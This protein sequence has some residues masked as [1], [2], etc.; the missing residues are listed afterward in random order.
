MER[1]PRLWEAKF[2]H[3]TTGRSGSTFI[4]QILKDVLG[5]ENVWAGHD[6]VAF[7]FHKGEKLVI[8]YRD[9]RD[10]AAS[11]WRINNDIQD[12]VLNSGA[13]KM[14]PKDVNHYS[15]MI[16]G[17][18]RGHMNP[19]YKAHPGALLMKYEDFFPDNYGYIFERIEKHFDIKLSSG[20]RVEIKKKYSLER[21][22]QRAAKFSSFKQVDREYVHGLHIYKGDIGTW[23][24]LVPANQHA[25]M[26]KILRP[27]LEEW[28]YRV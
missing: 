2:L 12:H 24:N 7:P 11:Y 17:L 1:M 25:V 18:V 22:K 27:F 13:R 19:T 8:T 10:V 15:N 14:S 3:Y 28:G 20:R 9:F 23:K 21:N 5:I 6:P 16:A 26:N 4:S